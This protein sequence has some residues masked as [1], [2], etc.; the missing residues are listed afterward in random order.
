MMKKWNII[1]IVDGVI[2][3]GTIHVNESDECECDY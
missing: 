3:D 2:F 1:R